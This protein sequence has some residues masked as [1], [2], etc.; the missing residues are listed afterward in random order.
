MI[1]Y[2][3]LT[4]LSS[5][6]A[7]E[8]LTFK[9]INAIKKGHKVSKTKKKTISKSKSNTKLQK[10]LDETKKILEGYRYVDS[11]RSKRPLIMSST[12][13]NEADYIGATSLLAI[14]ATNTPTRTSFTN[15]MGV[16]LPKDSKILCDV[17]TKYKRICGDCTRIIIHG[18]GHTI[19]AKLHNKDGSICTTGKVSDDK[20]KYLTGILLTE[21]AKGA[22]AVSQSSIPTISGSII[23]NT[24]KNK[25]A[26]GLINTGDEATDLMRKEYE[27][28]ESIV[29]LDKG[30]QVVIQFIE[31]FKL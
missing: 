13:I 15:L 27:T 22:L 3:F 6:F 2:L 4:L 8:I 25:I 24:A 29:T 11:I 7:S 28:T 20:E 17:F 19:K 12:M 23:K 26:Q 30:Q 18:K 9:E 16:D 31:E 1:Q 14:M 21:M 10:E 5:S